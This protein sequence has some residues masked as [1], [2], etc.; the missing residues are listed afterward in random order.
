V[1]A[2]SPDG[3]KIAFFSM[4][5]GGAGPGYYLMNP[6][7][8]GQASLTTSPAGQVLVPG[9]AS[10]APDG[11][12]LALVARGAASST[13]EIVIVNS[14]GVGWSPLTEGSEDAWPTWSPE[15][16]QIAF[17]SAGREAD[18]SLTGLYLVDADG[19]SP[20][21]LV[22]AVADRREAGPTWS[23]DGGTVAFDVPTCVQR[24]PEECVSRTLQIQAVDRDGSNLR[25]L[26]NVYD[27]IE[28]SQPAWSSQP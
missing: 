27:D 2:W 11:T 15:G 25:L 3:R 9:R 10:W 21:L 13:T 14:N 6:D 1:A 17:T 26:T 23:P 5:T 16:L 7:G 28:N 20:S 22:D 4:R 24:P 12:K 19:G 18:P 8:S